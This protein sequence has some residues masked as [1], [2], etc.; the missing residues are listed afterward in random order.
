MSPGEVVNRGEVNVYQGQLFHVS[1]VPWVV[2]LSPKLC[3]KLCPFAVGAK[4][5]AMRLFLNGYFVCSWQIE[6]LFREAL[7]TLTW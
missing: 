6:S 1:A 3:C 4:P 5:F 7:W 2:S